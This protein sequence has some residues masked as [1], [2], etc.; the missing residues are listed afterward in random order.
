MQQYA[1]IAIDVGDLALDRRRR[2]I[3]WVVGERT[4]LLGQRRNVDHRRTKSPGSHGQN[5]LLS[6][7]G[8]DE[9]KFRIGHAR[10]A[11]QEARREI[12]DGFAAALHGAQ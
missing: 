1:S 10:R 6:S 5:R 12:H 4:E 9:F 2:P 8:I 3:A 11:L 7:G